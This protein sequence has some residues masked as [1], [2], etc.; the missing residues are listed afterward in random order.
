MNIHYKADFGYNAVRPKVNA[1]NAFIPVNARETAIKNMLPAG[2]KRNF[3]SINIIDRRPQV[4]RELMKKFNIRKES[5]GNYEEWRTVPI[6]TNPKKDGDSG[7][8]TVLKY[9][10]L[11][12]KSVALRSSQSTQLHLMIKGVLYRSVN[13]E[14][15]IL[16]SE[17]E[18]AEKHC[19]DG[20]TGEFFT[21]K[22]GKKLDGDGPRAI[23][24]FIRKGFSLTLDGRWEPIDPWQGIYGEGDGVGCGKGDGSGDRNSENFLDQ[25]FFVNLGYGVDPDS[26]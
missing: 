25:G 1:K 23:K 3:R 5:Q 2:G 11:A 22:W 12:A 20:G 6:C 19:P 26:N 8:R 18:I 24:Q 13:L 4:L 7:V 17:L 10:G 16:A 14:R 21:D 15:I 9:P